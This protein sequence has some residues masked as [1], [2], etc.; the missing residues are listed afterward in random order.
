AHVLDAPAGKPRGDERH[1]LRLGDALPIGGEGRDRA[2]GH[3]L[4]E[5]AR[6]RLDLGQLRHQAW[7]GCGSGVISSQLSPARMST[8]SGTSSGYAFPISARTRSAS[9]SMRDRSTSKT[10]SSWTWSTA[11]AHAA[12][13]RRWCTFTLA[14]FMMSAAVP[15]IGMLIAMRSAALRTAPLLLAMS[16]M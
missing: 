16:G 11:C 5:L 15:W 10:S 4:R 6:D 12:W 13:R 1:R 2:T 14:I 9:S 8:T 3:Q 7:A